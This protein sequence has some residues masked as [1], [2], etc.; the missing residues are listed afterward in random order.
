MISLDSR[1]DC[2]TADGTSATQQRERQQSRA[3]RP[4]I[5]L[6]PQLQR[7][8]LTYKTDI[9]L[10]EYQ[11]NEKKKKRELTKFLMHIRGQTPLLLLL[12]CTEAGEAS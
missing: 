6:L 11:E 7:E 5:C 3:G 1:S 9:N 8:L 12:L 10:R 4:G 2:G